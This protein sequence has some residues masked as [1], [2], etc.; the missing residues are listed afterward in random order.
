MRLVGVL[1]IAG[2]R[3]RDESVFLCSSNPREI[4][5]ELKWLEAENKR[6]AFI[7]RQF[8]QHARAPRFFSS[9]GC[10]FRHIF[11]HSFLCSRQVL[12]HS[13][14]AFVRAFFLV[15][16]ECHLW[17]LLRRLRIRGRWRPM[18]WHGRKLRLRS[19]HFSTKE[20]LGEKAGNGGREE[21]HE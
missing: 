12:P 7:K 16:G 4:A 20:T 15:V 17:S 21:G 8:L 11:S 18:R 2:R 14:F 1:L 10:G 5:T 3:I 13:V 9:C 19:P 6:P